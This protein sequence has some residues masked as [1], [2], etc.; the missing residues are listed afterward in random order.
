MAANL[1]ELSIDTVLTTTP[2][3]IINSGNTEAVFIGQLVFTNTNTT[4]NREI[5]VWRLGD[6]TTQTAT[7]Y[8]VKKTIPPL[9]TWISQEVL[10]QVV[11]AGSK[12][13]ASQDTGTDVNVN[14]SGVIEV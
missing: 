10:G 8:L 13:Q 11:R 1:S 3:T 14:A 12:I 9:K 4:T 5:T 7:N 2:T 6:S